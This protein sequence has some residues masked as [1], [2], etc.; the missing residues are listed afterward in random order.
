MNNLPFQ[1]KY[2]PKRFSEMVGLDYLSKTIS[3]IVQN[4]RQS[5]ILFNGL[6]GHGKTTLAEICLQRFFCK[7]PEGLDACLKCEACKQ[8]EEQYHFSDILKISG[9][10]LTIGTLD[11]VDRFCSYVPGYLPRRT[12]FIDDLDLAEKLTIEKLKAA[13]DCYREDV[14]FLFT[15]TNLGIIPLPIVQRCKILPLIKPEYGPLEKFIYHICEL[16]GIRISEPESVHAL[17][18]LSN[19]TPRLIL[20]ALELIKEEGGGLS[21]A[22]LNSPLVVSNLQTLTGTY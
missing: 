15:V 22:G 13:I 1:Q 20:N 4:Q 5:T 8:V 3:S 19:Q 18:S 10:R 11:H 21:I 2:K 12:I 9:E 16:E 7:S 14:L 6:N 17:I